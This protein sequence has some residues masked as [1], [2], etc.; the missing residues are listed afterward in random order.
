[1][2]NA[3]IHK[4]SGMIEEVEKGLK[5]YQSEHPPS[6]QPFRPYGLISPLA[7]LHRRVHRFF[8]SRSMRLSEFKS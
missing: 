7:S 8:K 5:R 2:T 1:M 6:S 3:E 4:L